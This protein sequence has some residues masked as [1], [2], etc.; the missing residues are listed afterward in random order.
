GEQSNS[1]VTFGEQTQL[2]VFRRV[3]P[4]RNPDIEIHEALT[5]ADGEHI[6]SLV[7]WVSLQQGDEVLHLAMLQE[8]VRTAT[9]G[10]EV[11]L[12]SVRDLLAEGDLH[13]DEV[14][15]DFAGESHRLGAVVGEIHQTMATQLGEWQRDP[16]EIADGMQERLRQA[17]ASL[18]ALAEYADSISEYYEQVRT[19]AQA[20]PIQRIHGDLHLG[21]TLRDTMGWKI[22]DFE[23]EPAKPL[24]VRQQPDSPWRDVAG[25]LRSFDYAAAA[26]ADDVDPM[27]AAANQAQYRATEWRVRNQAAFLDGYLAHLGRPLTEWE[28]ILL[29]A[30]VVDKTVYEAIYEFHNRPDWLHIPMEALDR[31]RAGQMREQLP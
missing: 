20:V 19:I 16:I 14:G 26:G 13:A 23:G 27:G 4:G 30:Y 7:G 18:P 12:A 11:A 9:N 29:Q 28:D 25:M 31:I 5:R 2:K 15:G 1:S 3:T 21:Q 17:G 10:W 6:A 24:S 22:V 8:Y